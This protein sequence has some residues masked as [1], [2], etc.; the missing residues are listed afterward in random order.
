MQYV[1]CISQ[2]FISR[3]VKTPMRFSH[4]KEAHVK[5]AT[6]PPQLKPPTSLPCTHCRLSLCEC[7][8]CELW[9]DCTARASFC[10]RP[11]ANMHIRCTTVSRQ[12]DELAV[13]KNK[14]F[15]FW[16]WFFLQTLLILQHAGKRSSLSC[17]RN[18]PELLV[19]KVSN[20]G[21]N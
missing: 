4:R 1:S 18:H 5:C 21:G 9:T 3:K 20:V 15:W 13:R 17:E 2:D 8:W 19:W 11:A 14:M 7:L 16:F 12:G 10:T 6:A